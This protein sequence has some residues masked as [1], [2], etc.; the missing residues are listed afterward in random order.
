MKRFLSLVLVVISFTVCMNAQTVWNVK[1]YNTPYSLY[2]DT[3]NTDDTVSVVAFLSMEE[4][5]TVNAQAYVTA[6]G[7]DT[8]GGKVNVYRSDINDVNAYSLWFTM[9]TLS[10][11][12]TASF[13]DT[14][15]SATFI[16]YEMVASDTG[17]FNL[18]VKPIPLQ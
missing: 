16:K 3:L 18:L 13:T 6:V 17:I 5:H 4:T 10:P 2:G 14:T 11:T 15:N 8:I 1:K 7:S 12:N 9:S